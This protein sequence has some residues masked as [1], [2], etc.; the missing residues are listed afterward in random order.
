MVEEWSATFS[1]VC[2]AS[3]PG[4]TVSASRQLTPNLPLLYNQVSFTG[5]SPGLPRCRWG[6][7]LL[8][9]VAAGA[10]ANLRRFLP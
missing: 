3:K 7:R 2:R 1:T 10:D 6:N 9:P 8:F 5:S 4:T